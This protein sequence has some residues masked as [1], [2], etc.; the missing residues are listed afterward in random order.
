MM[1]DGFLKFVV[2]N[3]A[4]IDVL[5]MHNRKYAAEIASSV[6]GRKRKAI[7]ERAAALNVKVTNKAARV[8]SQESA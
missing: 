1:P 7:L 5:L 8:R 6:S 4:D 2:N 3:V